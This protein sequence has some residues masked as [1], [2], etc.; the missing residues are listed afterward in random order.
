ML[1]S[2]LFWTSELWT[3]QAGSHKRK[4]S[5]DFLHLPF[6]VFG[7]IISHEGFSRKFPSS[8]VKSKYVYP[9]IHRSPL[10]GHD[11][12]FYCAQ[13]ELLICKEHNFFCGVSKKYSP[14]VPR[15]VSHWPVDTR[16]LLASGKSVYLK[17]NLNAPR[18]SFRS[19]DTC[20]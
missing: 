8:T 3:H 18:P 10:C 13:S 15:N 5:Q 11:I 2:H 16:I 1:S 20:R 14:R 19:G 7:L 17:K 6:A 4:V 12:Y 9:R